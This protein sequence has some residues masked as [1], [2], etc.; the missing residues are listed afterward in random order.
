MNKE[1]R[2]ICEFKINFNAKELCQLGNYKMP[3]QLRET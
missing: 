2:E 1:E 3:V